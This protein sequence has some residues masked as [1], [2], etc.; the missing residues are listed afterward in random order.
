M[1]KYAAAMARVISVSGVQQ[2]VGY[3]ACCL[4]SAT[5]VELFCTAEQVKQPVTVQY[6]STSRFDCPNTRIKRAGYSA[7]PI[8]LTN[9]FTSGCTRDS[10]TDRHLGE[11]CCRLLRALCPTAGTRTRK[12]IDS[13]EYHSSQLEAVVPT[14]SR[15]GSE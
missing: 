4:L 8:W 6:C 11:I 3:L 9:C 5:V 15:N 1:Y 2:Q 10:T 12:D 13:G 14:Q 7:K